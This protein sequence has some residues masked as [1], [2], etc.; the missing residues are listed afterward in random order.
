MWNWLGWWS[1]LPEREELIQEADILKE[2]VIQRWIETG[3]EVCE[4][5]YLF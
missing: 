2:I 5:D 4:V 3:W 1:R